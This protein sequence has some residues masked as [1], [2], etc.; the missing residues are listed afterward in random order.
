ME[1]SI[2]ATKSEIREHKNPSF[3]NVHIIGLDMGYSGVKCFHE[4]GNFVFPN[5]CQKIEGEIFG[6]LSRND[7]IY[8]DL[9]S[10]DRYYVGA[11]AIKS[12]SEDSTVA[13]DKILG[14][15]HYGHMDFL[16][17][18]RTAL[19]LARWDILEDEPLFI[20][21]G[22]PPAYI[23][24][25]EM[26]LRNAIQQSHDFALISC[27][28]RKEFHIDITAEDVDVMYQPMGTFYSVTTDQ[29]GNL[30]NDL[31]TFRNSDLLVFD[32]G[33]KTLDKFV[34][35]NKKLEEK[36][37]DE[38]LGMK[39]ILEETRNSMQEDLKRKGYSV[40]VSLPAMQQCLKNGVVRIN[41]RINF[42]VKEFP[43]EEYL[44]K[45]ND[46]V[47]KEAFDSIKDYVFN[48]KYLIMTGGTG[49]AWYGY[50]KDKLKRIPTLKVI[51]GDY[52][53]NLPAFYANARGYYMYR[54]TQF[55]VKR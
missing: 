31:K 33:F 49:S 13:E 2:F 22:L 32:G 25:D 10:G 29:F 43:I 12:L 46:L 47:C 50:F 16:I 23:K 39:R 17:K 18:F 53:S 21:T 34:I 52:N 4:N 15:N 30:T 5:Y 54:L 55:K 44:K 37:T 38:N 45:A 28:K 3:G 7:L 51:S 42:T 14:R 41:D 8:E 27:G 48:I 40:S 1:T 24:T 6:D 36:D 20:Q 11:L 26:L 9:K 35:Q 19:G